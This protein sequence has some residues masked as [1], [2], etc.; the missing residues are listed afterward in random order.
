[1]TGRRFVPR[2]MLVASL[3]TAAASLLGGSASANCGPQPSASVT[4]ARIS[5][6]DL[7]VAASTAAL[8]AEADAGLA[9][10]KVRETLSGDQMALERLRWRL[11]MDAESGLITLAEFR[12]RS[13]IVEAALI[14]TTATG[15]PHT[16][17]APP[18]RIEVAV[19]LTAC[20][21][22]R[23]D[24]IIDGTK[25]MGVRDGATGYRDTLDRGIHPLTLR[26]YVGND[27]TLF[28]A[29][30]DIFVCSTLEKDVQD[31]VFTISCT[32]FAAYSATLLSRPP[33]TW[34]C[35]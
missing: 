18:E 16:T 32:E 6:V 23:M 10:A 8:G 13:S 4:A 24:L 30:R 26:K 29:G 22:N 15:A 7:K 25:S 14:A 19:H 2:Q 1:M 9:A 34:T 33:G 27:G 21:R 3:V 11:C 12:R 17:P 31:A 35:E 28:S 5:E 20:D